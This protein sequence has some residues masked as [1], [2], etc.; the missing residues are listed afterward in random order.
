MKRYLKIEELKDKKLHIFN[1]AP[2]SDDDIKIGTTKK[3]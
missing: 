1:D 3:K 2:V